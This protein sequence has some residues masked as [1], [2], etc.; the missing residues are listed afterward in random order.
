LNS[1]WKLDP[2]QDSDLKGVENRGRGVEK[3]R[4][5]VERERGDFHQCLQPARGIFKITLQM[6]YEQYVHLVLTNPTES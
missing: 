2:Y 6:K 4:G 1:S 3:D 5:R